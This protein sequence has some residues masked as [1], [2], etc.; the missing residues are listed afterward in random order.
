M[1]NGE[2]DGRRVLIVGGAGRMGRAIA[3]RAAQMGA[4][5]ILAGRDGASLTEAA[6]GLSEPQIIVG[7]AAD[8]EAAERLYA[9]VGRVDHMVVAVSAGPVRASS[10]P[11]TT[12]ADARLAFGKVWVSFAALHHAARNVADGGS[13]T[14]LS[15]SS[16]RRAGLGFGVWTGVHAAIEG[17]ARAAAIELAPIR[18]NVVSPGGIGLK[19][20]RQLVPRQGQADDIARAVLAIIANPAVTGAVLDVDSGERL[21]AWS[22]VD[23]THGRATP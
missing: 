9:K 6:A 21:G 20:D 15:G 10:I 12:P 14:L 18:V 17:L 3:A 4:Q 8:A 13:V 19:P 23:T 11:A 5:V 16:A 2:L 7:D 1:Q 22:G